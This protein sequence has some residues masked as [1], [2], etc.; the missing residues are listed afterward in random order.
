MHAG[1][2]SEKQ[3][4]SFIVDGY[5]ETEAGEREVYEF[6]GCFWHGC[7]KCFGRSTINPVTGNTMADLFQRTMDKRSFLE[8]DGYKNI[9][10]GEYIIASLTMN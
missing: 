10:I 3:I 4:G 1:N 8:K 6:H 9:S 5:R 7:E 2:G